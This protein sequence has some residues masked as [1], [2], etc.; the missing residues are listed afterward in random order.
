MSR[1]T[2]EAQAYHVAM[3]LLRTGW[4]RFDRPADLPKLVSV[5]LEALKDDATRAI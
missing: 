5:I 2:Y 3:T 1:A 4:V